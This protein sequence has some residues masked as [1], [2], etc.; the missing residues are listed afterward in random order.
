MQAQEDGATDGGREQGVQPGA[1]GGHHQPC[2][3]IAGDIG[4]RRIQPSKYSSGDVLAP[5][6]ISGISGQNNM[7]SPVLLCKFPLG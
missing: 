2:D 6:L 4:P 5:Y 7:L 1:R 3:Y